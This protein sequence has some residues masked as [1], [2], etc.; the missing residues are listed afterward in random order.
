MLSQNYIYIYN[1]LLPS[2]FLQIGTWI[3]NL[4]LVVWKFLGLQNNKI[5]LNEVKLQYTVIFLGKTLV[6][7]NVPRIGVKLNRNLILSVVSY[8]R[9]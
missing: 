6:Y 3:Y 9:L 4:V 1:D 8:R 2:V 7:E 5:F